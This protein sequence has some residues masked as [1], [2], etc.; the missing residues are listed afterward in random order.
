M[1]ENEMVGGHHGLSGH[2]IEQDLGD[3][4]GSLACCSSWD[5]KESDTNERLKNTT[6]NWNPQILS[7]KE[8]LGKPSNIVGDRD[9]RENLTF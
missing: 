9:I 1:S 3:G 6:Q 4:E 8:F 5:H 2:E 7:K